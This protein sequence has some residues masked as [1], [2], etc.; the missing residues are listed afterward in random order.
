MLNNLGSIK[1][2]SSSE[3]VVEHDVIKLAHIPGL[4]GVRGLAALMIMFLH[5]VPN[6][7]PIVHPFLS[8]V[9]KIAIIG[10][11]GVPLFFVL[12]GFLITRI[13][14]YSKLYPN[15]FKQFY[16]K[17]VLRIFP[18]YYLY[19]IITFFLLPLLTHHQLPDWS[20]TWYYYFYLQNIPMTFN[21]KAADIPHLWSLAVEE[22]FYLVWP[23]IVYFFSDKATVRI[24]AGIVLF[25]L[26]CR[27]IL[28]HFG[29]GT[30]YFTLTTFDSLALGAFLALNEKYKW[31][32]MKNMLQ[33]AFITVMPLFLAFPFATGLGNNFVQ[34]FKNPIISIFCMGLIGLVSMNNYQANYFFK[35]RFLRY[36]GKISYGLYVFHPTCYGIINTHFHIDNFIM[37]FIFCFLCSYIVATLSYYCFEV[38]FLKLKSKL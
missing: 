4:D 10:Q 5:F 2:K 26:L 35:N 14:L 33:I 24:I 16:M 15:Y 17:R 34:Y 21:L 31:L 6:Y 8:Y 18:L 27:I 23:I 19:L 38:R 20:M 32:N 9:R 22:H 29:I 36:T 28:I 11:C 13:L 37:N 25:A 1:S 30:Y 7:D 12:S 3:V